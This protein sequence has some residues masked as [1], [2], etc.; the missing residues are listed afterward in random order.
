MS[1]RLYS[2]E[3]VA[4]LLRRTRGY[5]L[6]HQGEGSYGYLLNDG[7]CFKCDTSATVRERAYGVIDCAFRA[8]Q[9]ANRAAF[10]MTYEGRHREGGSYEIPDFPEVRDVW[11]EDYEA[12]GDLRELYQELGLLSY[13]TVTNGG[14]DFLPENYKR[15]LE[16]VKHQI[17]VELADPWRRAD[18]VRRDPPRAEVAP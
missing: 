16:W 6:R 18:S 5:L 17:L 1:V 15:A 14:T 12:P 9:I 7:V 3:E 2:P 4:R 13:N 10:A 11:E 8:A